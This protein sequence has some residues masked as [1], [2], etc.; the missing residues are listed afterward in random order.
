M[1][2]CCFRLGNLTK[3]RKGESGV[4]ES[5]I[6]Y[7]RRRAN[8]ELAAANRAVTEAARQRRLKLVDLYVGHLK[9]LDAPDAFAEEPSAFAWRAGSRARS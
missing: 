9:A 6:R 8:E 4:V 1:L 5:D 3:H 7:Y 2:T